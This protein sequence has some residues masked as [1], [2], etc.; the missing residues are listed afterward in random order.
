MQEACRHAV[1]VASLEEIDRKLFVCPHLSKVWNIRANNGQP[2]FTGPP[3]AKPKNDAR[4][5]PAHFLEMHTAM[6]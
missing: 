5:G 2:V 3:T 4:K 1:R 6:A